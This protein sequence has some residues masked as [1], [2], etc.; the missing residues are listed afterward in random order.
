MIYKK[1]KNYIKTSVKIFPSMNLFLNIL[2]SGSNVFKIILN[3]NKFK[4]IIF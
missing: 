2:L 4:K 1:K 3:L